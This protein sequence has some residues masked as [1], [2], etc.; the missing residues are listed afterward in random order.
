M[1]AALGHQDG[2][3]QSCPCPD[4]EE[5]GEEQQHG[6]VEADEGGE[7]D[8]ARDPGKAAPQVADARLADVIARRSASKCE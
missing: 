4:D 3:Q 8:E 5:D 2:C 6:A 1:P 7:A